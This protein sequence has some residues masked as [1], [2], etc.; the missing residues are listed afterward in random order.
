MPRRI[1]NVLLLSG[2]AA[3]L[4][5]LTVLGG[6]ALYQWYE[7][8]A[9]D[10]AVRAGS[11]ALPIYYAPK[12]HDVIGRLE[13]PR[14]HVAT[15]VLEGDDEGAL[16]LGAGHVPGTALPGSPGNSGIAA[17]RDTYFLPLRRIARNDRITLTTPRGAFHY[18]VESTEVV[19]PD[20]VGV[21]NASAHPE[22]TLITCYPF[23]YVGSAPLRFVVHARQTS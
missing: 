5:C 14:L 8:R 9:L 13:I 22:L 19:K 1:A 21:L 23:T 6:A 12:P 7:N 11:Q 3:L 15:V 2:S 16:R 20:D 17:H 4:W 18:V 10:H